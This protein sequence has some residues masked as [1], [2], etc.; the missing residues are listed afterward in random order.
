MRGA[1]GDLKKRGKPQKRGPARWV[2]GNRRDYRNLGKEIDCKAGKKGGKPKW[3][4][5]GRGWG[6][7]LGGLL[8]SK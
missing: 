3:G 8:A 7:N 2:E 1:R 6:G 5:K 4:G